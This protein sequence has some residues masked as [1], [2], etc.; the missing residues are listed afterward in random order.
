MANNWVGV[1]VAYMGFPK[2]LLELVNIIKTLKKK[3]SW[4]N[5]FK[6]LLNRAHRKYRHSSWVPGRHQVENATHRGRGV[7]KNR[8]K[9]FTR[10]Q[11]DA[12]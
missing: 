6:C 10:I 7:G 8:A 9:G 5:T 1:G 2:F 11:S 4:M 12:N 3:R